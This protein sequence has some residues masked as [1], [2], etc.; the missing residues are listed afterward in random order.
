MSSY[1]HFQT[2]KIVKKKKNPLLPVD[3]WVK[4]QP[5]SYPP[6]PLW[7]SP[8]SPWPQPS[9]K[10]RESL[11]WLSCMIPNSWT[12]ESV[13]LFTLSGGQFQKLKFFKDMLYEGMVETGWLYGP[14]KVLNVIYRFHN[15]CTKTV[16]RWDVKSIITFLMWLACCL[17]HGSHGMVSYKMI[18]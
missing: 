8:I 3:H 13:W 12:L 18:S 4:N 15:H 2:R 14:W 5:V 7:K 9:E 6:I 1:E 11:R 10:S 17:I 16:T